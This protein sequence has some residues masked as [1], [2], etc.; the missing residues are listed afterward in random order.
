MFD[1]TKFLAIWG[2]SLST[3]ALGWN[4]YRDLLD[5][6]KLYV[7]AALSRLAVGE[8][9]KVYAVKHDLPVMGTST[10][11]FLMLSVT[12]VGRRPV[13][14][15]AWGGRWR[16]PV[17][18]KKEFILLAGDMPKMLREGE[19]HQEPIPDLNAVSE[20]V[21]CLC[22]WDSSGKEWKVPNREFRKLKEEAR[23]IQELGAS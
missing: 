20:R 21:K 22:V 15:K 11:V 14:L 7:T 10:Q 1:L 12:N 23:G 3:F 8:D 17:N 4:F 16:S 2:A 18:G 9:K 13:M 19:F 5:R 6:P